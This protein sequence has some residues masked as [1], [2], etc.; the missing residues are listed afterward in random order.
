MKGNQR[1]TL[2][3]S[4]DNVNAI[5]D[6]FGLNNLMDRLIAKLNQAIKT[7]DVNNTT[8][9]IRSGFNYDNDNP[10]LIEWMPLYKKNEEVVI[11]VVGYHPKNPIKH[12][13]PTI[14]STISSYDTTTGHLKGLVDGVLLTA[15]RTGATSAVA[16]KY[17][18]QPDSSVLGLI[19][20][21]A[22][23]ITQLHALSRIFDFKKVLIYD[24]DTKATA[25][26]R[27]RSE[28]LD[29][30]IEV[31]EAS[32]DLIMKQSDIVCTATSIDVGEGPLFNNLEL[33]S[34]IHINAVGSD[35]PGKTELPLQL[36]KKSIVVPDFLK[37]AV[38]EGECQQLETNDIGPDLVDLI[39]NYKN[40]DATKNSIT[41]FDSTGWALEDQV[42]MDLFLELAIEFE[43]G[44]EL[45]IENTSADAKNPYHYFLKKI[46]V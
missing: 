3:L 8:I 4:G 24:V 36:L 13:L 43:I 28:M 42:V 11:K 26:F 30:S 38:I 41:V 6:R 35:F 46:E 2:V 14:L 45:D 33:K 40:Y 32:L 9:P 7:F 15:L 29:L 12:S 16:S 31:I 21:G 18:A 27:D 25:S 19:G 17:L 22:Q 39:Q 34:N 37:Q 44:L 20:C 1:K 5:V 10:G 23:S